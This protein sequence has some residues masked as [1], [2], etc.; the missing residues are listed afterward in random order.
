MYSFDT[1]AT[2]DMRINPVNKGN[3]NSNN[4]VDSNNGQTASQGT[5]DML[6][7]LK[8]EVQNLGD[9]LAKLDQAVMAVQGQQGQGQV[10][11]SCTVN[12]SLSKLQSVPL[13]N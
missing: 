13:T 4:S 12:A 6:V 5:M 11:Q 2:I 9:E 10:G 1:V 3:Y 7:A 8:E